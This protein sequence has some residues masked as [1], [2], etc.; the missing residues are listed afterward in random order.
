MACRLPA[1]ARTCKSDALCCEACPCKP[2]ATELLTHKSHIPAGI[3]C[4]QVNQQRIHPAGCP[5]MLCRN[6]CTSLAVAD[7]CQTDVAEVQAMSG[8]CNLT[9]NTDIPCRHPVCAS[10]SATYTPGGWPITLSP[11][12]CTSL[13]V[14]GCHQTFSAEVQA[15]AGICKSVLIYTQQAMQQRICNL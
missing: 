4:V 2:A 10:Q 5:I 14:V 1:L 11:N 6:I 3:L 9:H 15:A 7:N 8:T 13:A 12:A